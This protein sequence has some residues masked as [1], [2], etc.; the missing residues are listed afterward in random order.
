MKTTFFRLV[1]L[2]IIA[3]VGIVIWQNPGQRGQGVLHTLVC[4]DLH[5]GCRIDLDGQAVAVSVMGELKPLR[6][7][8]VRVHAPR[9]RKVEARFSMEG[10]DM[11]FNLYRLRA[12]KDGVFQARVTLPGCVTGRREWVMDLDVDGA[13]VAVPFVTDL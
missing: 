7:F 4:P 5:Q 6:A 2:L 3:V 11:G 1:P 12:D 13:R 10:M 9:A 8:H